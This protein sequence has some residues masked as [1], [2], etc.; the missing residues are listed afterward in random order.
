M[1]NAASVQMP[2]MQ[3]FTYFFAFLIAGLIFLVIAFSLFLPIIILAPNKFAISFTIASAFI[4]AALTALKGWRQQLQ[5]MMTQE[6]LPFTAGIC[7]ASVPLA[8]LCAW[9]KLVTLAEG[10]TFTAGCR[11]F[12]A[13]SQL[14]AT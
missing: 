1:H 3:Q 8:V 13:S 6:R 10:S 11:V 9:Q 5:H 4:M 7:K 2:N 14:L 12:K